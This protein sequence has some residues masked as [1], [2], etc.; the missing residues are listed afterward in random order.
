M[1]KNRIIV[2][3]EEADRYELPLKYYDT[4]AQAARENKTQERHMHY[5][6][7]SR[8]SFNGLKFEKI[9]REGENMEK[10]TFSVFEQFVRHT[11]GGIEGLGDSQ[12]MADEYGCES[13]EFFAPAD[14]LAQERATAHG[15]EIEGSES[16]EY[17]ESY[18]SIQVVKNI[19]DNK[20]ELEESTT[21]LEKYYQKYTL[22]T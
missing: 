6:I 11:P 14:A 9:K 3:Y 21:M 19:Y 17:H 7:N 5:I 20:G 22:S 4:I 8:S 1:A 16:M 2:A 13:F 18:V 10:V 12:I 15:K